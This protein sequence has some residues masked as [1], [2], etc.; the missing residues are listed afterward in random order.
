M[1][2]SCVGL[3]S[4]CQ[5]ESCCTAITL[6]AG[7]FPMGRGLD[8]AYATGSSNELPEHPATVTSFALDKYEVTVGRFRKFVEAY[9]DWHV[10]RSLPAS[11]TGANPNSGGTGWNT[12]WPLPVSAVALRSAIK[13]GDLTWTDLQGNNESSAINCVSWSEAFAFCIWD[14]GRLPTEAEWEYAAAG[15]AQNHL[16]AWGNQAPSAERALFDASAN[17]PFTPVGSKATTG[18]RG[19]YGHLDLAGSVSEWAFDFYAGDYYARSNPCVDCANW[20]STAPYADYH[21]ARGGAWDAPVEY[22]RAAFRGFYFHQGRGGGMGQRCA[23][24]AQ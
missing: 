3:L 9:D 5:G 24:P 2:N 17:S 14:G 11:G 6:P 1:T 16:Y 21:V 10:A 8:D 13:C 22:I 23:R 19:C 20:L 12:A 15:G 4:T 7:T 18:G